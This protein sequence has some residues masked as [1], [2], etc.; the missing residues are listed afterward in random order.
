M[1]VQ[2][3]LITVEAYEQFIALPANKNRMFEL[4]DVEIVVKLPT[5]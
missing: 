1:V 2:P 5:L 4:I 3:H